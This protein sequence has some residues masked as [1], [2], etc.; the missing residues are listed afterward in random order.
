MPSDARYEVR[1]APE[2][3]VYLLTEHRI[4]SVTA[5]TNCLR[6]RLEDGSVLTMWDGDREYAREWELDRAA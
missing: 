3:A 4:M 2:R 5:M 1:I 6:F